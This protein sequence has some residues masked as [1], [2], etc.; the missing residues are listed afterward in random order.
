MKIRI[1]FSSFG[2]VSQNFYLKDKF[3]ETTIFFGQSMKIPDSI[4][5]F[6][7]CF[8]KFVLEKNIL[9]NNNFWPK[10]LIVFFEWVSLVFQR[11]TYKKEQ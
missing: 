2:P 4:S 10:R 6:G 5:S 1:L 7:P 9:E 8:P 3:W 11:K